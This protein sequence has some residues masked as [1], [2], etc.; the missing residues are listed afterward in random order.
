MT[1]KLNLIEVDQSYNPK[2]GLVQ[3]SCYEFDLLKEKG[4]GG[5]SRVF[6]GDKKVN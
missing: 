1:N 4:R 6:E 2:S 5:F 3:V